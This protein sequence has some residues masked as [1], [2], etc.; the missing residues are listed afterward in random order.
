MLSVAHASCSWSTCSHFSWILLFPLSNEESKFVCK[1]KS[2]NSEEM[3]NIEWPAKEMAFP[4]SVQ[5]TR[6]IEH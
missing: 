5:Y 6:L 4:I 1:H 3:G 2:L